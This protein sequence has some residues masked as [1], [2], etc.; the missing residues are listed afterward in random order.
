V[1]GACVAERESLG[2]A[3]QVGVGFV[4]NDRRRCSPVEQFFADGIIESELANDL[5]VH[6]V[7]TVLDMVAET[8]PIDMVTIQLPA[9]NP[10]GIEIMEQRGLARASDDP[11]VNVFQWKR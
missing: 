5:D 3:T 7:D 8:W 4:D 10:R 9:Q 11:K 1:A 2:K 6:V